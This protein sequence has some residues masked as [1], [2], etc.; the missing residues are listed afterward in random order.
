LIDKDGDHIL[1]AYA[2]FRRTRED[3]DHDDHAP[4]P[5]IL[6]FLIDRFGYV[7]ARWIEGERPSLAEIQQSCRQLAKEPRILPS[8]DDHAH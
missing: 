3:P 7:R 4:S 5:S 2:L 6:Q 1:A 8:P